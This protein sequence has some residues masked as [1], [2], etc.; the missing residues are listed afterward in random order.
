MKTV[1]VELVKYRYVINDDE[2]YPNHNSKYEEIVKECKSLGYKLKDTHPVN[3]KKSKDFY[4]SLTEEVEIDTAHLFNNQFNT[5]CGKRVFLWHE[6]VFTNN[7]VKQGYFLRGDG[8]K[9]LKELLNNTLSCGYCG[10]QYP[11]Q[12]TDFKYCNN[13]LNSEHLEHGDLPLLLLLPINSKENRRKN[14]AL[15]DKWIKLVNDYQSAQLKLK[16]KRAKELLE[17]LDNRYRIERYE[18]KVK[19][20]ILMLG[21]EV[22]NL[23]YYSS[24]DS[25]VYGWRVRVD[26]KQFEDFRQFLA[27]NA[28]KIERDCFG[29]DIC[30]KLSMK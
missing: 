1:K 10:K 4:D 18:T 2:Y 14:I 16:Q 22:D 21:K 11:K 30:N 3:Y 24:K 27:E 13:C 5:V 9:E 29:I 26:P 17:E 23:R 15:D 8:I 25:W 12:E 28:D 20:D 6:F 19:H 7:D